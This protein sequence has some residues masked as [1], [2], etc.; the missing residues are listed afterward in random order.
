MSIFVE[1]QSISFKF[2]TSFH[3]ETDVGCQYDYVKIYAE[4]SP[5][6]DQEG[7][8]TDILLLSG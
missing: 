2:A 7:N 8:D 5:L 1:F 6:S 4:G 3:I